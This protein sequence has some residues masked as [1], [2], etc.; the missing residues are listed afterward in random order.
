MAKEIPSFYVVRLPGKVFQTANGPTSTVSQANQFPS[1]Q[2]AFDAA[3][4]E[5]IGISR[6]STDLM[7][8]RHLAIADVEK[9]LSPQED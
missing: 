4:D 1:L 9:E 2:A 8:L 5:A 3:S 6:Y 7:P